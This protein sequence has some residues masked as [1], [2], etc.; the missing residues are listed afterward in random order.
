MT[1]LSSLG[2]KDKMNV[3]MGVFA[4][5]VAIVVKYKLFCV[6]KVVPKT[7]IYKC[8]Q[9][10]FENLPTC[11]LKGVSISMKDFLL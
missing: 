6:A 3:C 8:W 11:K 4:T 9:D 1:A 5:A 2:L 10:L 7:D